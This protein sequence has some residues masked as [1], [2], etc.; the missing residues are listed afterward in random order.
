MGEVHLA[1]QA[2]REMAIKVF[3]PAAVLEQTEHEEFLKR[4]EDII[5]QCAALNHPHILPIL[6]HGRQTG[7][8]YQVMP[9]NAGESLETLL[10]RAGALPLA[11][12]QIYLA[13]LASA[14]DYAHTHGILH[15]DIKP[16]NI[17]LTPEGNLLLSDFGVAS[18]TTEKNFART[19]RATTR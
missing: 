9:Y 16:A 19:R 11:Q 17:L 14:L 15:R 8:V 12:I 3:L 4:L 1:S 7:L 6:N 5:T 13:Q 2:D 18:L 10:S